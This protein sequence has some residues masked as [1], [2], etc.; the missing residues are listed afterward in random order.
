[1]YYSS[2]KLV[3]EI[4]AS[5]GKKYRDNMNLLDNGLDY[6][7]KECP[8][9][10]KFIDKLKTKLDNIDKAISDLVNDNAK[11]AVQIRNDFK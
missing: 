9:Q 3:F 10:G 2:E 11:T 6:L 1:M 8:K 5:Y 7:K 4:T